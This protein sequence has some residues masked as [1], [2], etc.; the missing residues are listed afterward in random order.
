MTIRRLVRSPVVKLPAIGTYARGQMEYEWDKVG[1]VVAHHDRVEDVCGLGDTSGPCEPLFGPGVTLRVLID[2][3]EGPIRQ[4]ST[5]ELIFHHS[6][7]CAP[8]E[9][10]LGRLSASTEEE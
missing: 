4:E 5:M 2:Y 9:K 10:D 7:L 3:D 8:S 1:V 6:Q